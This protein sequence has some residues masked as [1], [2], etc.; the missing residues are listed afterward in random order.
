MSDQPWWAL[1]RGYFWLNCGG[2]RQKWSFCG[3][4]KL[5]F[6]Q[7]ALCVIRR[8]VPAASKGNCFL[9]Q[10]TGDQSNWLTVGISQRTHLH[11]S[12][13]SSQSH[14]SSSPWWLHPNY[15]NGSVSYFPV[16]KWS[17]AVDWTHLTAFRWAQPHRE[18]ILSN[19]CFLEETWCF[20][21]GSEGSHEGGGN[22]EEEENSF[23]ILNWFCC[24]AD[25]TQSTTNDLLMIDWISLWFHVSRL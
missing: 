2:F 17:R 24:G 19:R 5:L 8:L 1:L 15:E 13:T 23:L 10:R 4:W 9:W 3:G 11:S 20:Y 7:R 25:V 21:L 12:S 16:G 22:G 6:L 14:R 18:L